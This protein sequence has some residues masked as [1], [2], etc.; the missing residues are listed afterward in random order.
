MLGIVCSP[1]LLAATIRHHL[2]QDGSE[3]AKEL[4]DTIYSDNV[5]ILAKDELEAVSKAQRA[6]EIFR[7]AG[8]NLKEFKSNSALV[9]KALGTDEGVMSS[10]LGVKWNVENDCLVL[11]VL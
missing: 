8:L 7:D 5:L 1:F 9:N 11:N 10:F 3:H 6:R 4:M 2:R